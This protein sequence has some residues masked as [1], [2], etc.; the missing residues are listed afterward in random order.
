MVPRLFVAWFC[1]FAQRAWL[2]AELSQ[3]RVHIVKDAILLDSDVFPRFMLKNLDFHDRVVVK[4]GFPKATVPFL[5]DFHSLDSIEIAAKILGSN[6]AEIDA[7]KNFDKLLCGPVF[8]GCL[9]PEIFKDRFVLFVR[10]LEELAPRF[11]A[12]KFLG[13]GDKPGLLDVVLFPFLWRAATLCLFERYRG[14]ILTKENVPFEWLD[15]MLALQG[16]KATLPLDTDEKGFSLSLFNV[17][18]VYVEGGLLQGLRPRGANDQEDVSLPENL[19]E[20]YVKG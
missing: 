5:E 4:E 12:S 13:G 19:R 20:R 10:A 9:K 15:A 3:A 14:L 11:R 16:V 1:P 8:Y 2:A 18:P 17:Y 7:A 6:E